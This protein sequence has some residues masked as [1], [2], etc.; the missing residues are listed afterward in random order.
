[1]ESYALF[2]FFH[3]ELADW[4][5]F[6]ADK[7]EHISI[8]EDIGYKVK[9]KLEFLCIYFS[10]FG[11]KRQGDQFVFNLLRLFSFSPLILSLSFSVESSSAT[12]VFRAINRLEHFPLMPFPVEVEC[13]LAV[14]LRFSC[15]QRLRYCDKQKMNIKLTKRQ[16]R[17]NFREI[18]GYLMV[19]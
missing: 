11:S 3:N 2:E 16:S 13:L 5:G 18:F 8:L 15:H 19:L 6:S 7:D 1:M 4:K 10:L 9:C 12:I 17:A 14:V